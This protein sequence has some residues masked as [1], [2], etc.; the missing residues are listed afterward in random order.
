MNPKE[1]PDAGRTRS[2]RH[3]YLSKKRGSKTP[4]PSYKGSET[5]HQKNCSQ[6][7]RAEG[8]HLTL[9][10]PETLEGEQK[11]HHE[12]P[13]KERPPTEKTDGKTAKNPRTTQDG[14]MR[15][16]RHEHYNT[17]QVV[18]FKFNSPS[19]LHSTYNSMA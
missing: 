7:H 15:D 6:T 8:M 10:E 16:L 12:N 19:S 5:R 2:E 1:N 13:P 3:T 11:K 9:N 14:P 18:G 4:N 17:R